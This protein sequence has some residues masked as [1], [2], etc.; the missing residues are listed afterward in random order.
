MSP[1]RTKGVWL[2]AER[3]PGISKLI[4]K[5]RQAIA[6]KKELARV[7]RRVQK[8]ELRAAQKKPTLNELQIPEENNPIVIAPNTQ[9]PS[10]SE[11]VKECKFCGEVILA[12]AIK[13]RF[14]NEFLDGRQRE[15]AS[16]TVNQSK[17]IVI[18]QLRPP[19]SN[20]GIA[21]I[22]SLL[23]PGLG[24]LYKGQVLNG[25]VWMFLVFGGYVFFVIPG[26]FLHVCLR[27]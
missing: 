12:K 26:V 14:C 20:L 13:C 19:E 15:I 17:T 5:R 7:E 1:S 24:Q 16:T 23:F 25:F 11:S 6:T 22:L 4:E 27:C 18:R 3:I 10:Q 2:V 21:A 9:N 8:Q